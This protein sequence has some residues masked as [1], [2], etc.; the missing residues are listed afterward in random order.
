M[1]FV[2]NLIMFVVILKSRVTFTNLTLNKFK[3]VAHT[4]IPL[5]NE[6]EG[7]NEPGVAKK[8]DST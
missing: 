1:K 4:L 6:S 3:A 2:L 7:L 5:T 8:P